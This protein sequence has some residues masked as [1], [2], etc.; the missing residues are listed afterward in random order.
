MRRGGSA[1]SHAR[2]ERSTWYWLDDH[3]ERNADLRAPRVPALP[4]SVEQ[5]S[6]AERVRLGDASAEETVAALFHERVRLM[7]LARTRRFD[8]A[9]ELAQDVVVAM[10]NGLRNGRLRDTEKLT[11]F[12]YGI[13]RN[14][15]NDYFRT[16]GRRPEELPLSPDHPT[17]ERDDE[18]EADERRMLVRSALKTLKASDRKILL[19]TLV[20]D[21]KPGD[22]A[23]R[24]G[25]TDEVVRARKSRALKKVIEH[26]RSLS[27]TDPR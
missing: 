13:A 23:R 17:A 12:A 8:V 21:L 15:I 19:L 6:L 1:T 7:A 10:I 16:S 26:V 14:F 18:L 4:E 27:R 2:G 20:D 9:D 3:A 24:L 11:A 5:A 25:L 22:I